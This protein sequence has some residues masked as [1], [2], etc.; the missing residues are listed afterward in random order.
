MFLCRFT[1]LKLLSEIDV[2]LPRISVS[3]RI[4]PGVL[5]LVRSSKLRPIKMYNRPSLA[6]YRGFTGVPPRWCHCESGTAEVTSLLGV[7]RSTYGVLSNYSYSANW[8]NAKAWAQLTHALKTE[9]TEIHFSTST[10]ACQ[11]SGGPQG[12]PHREKC[13][14]L[15]S[16]HPLP[17]S[18]GSLPPL[19]ASSGSPSQPANWFQFIGHIHDSQIP[20]FCFVWILLALQSVLG[21]RYSRPA[22]V[23]LQSHFPA[24]NLCRIS[25]QKWLHWHHGVSASSFQHT[26]HSLTSPCIKELEVF[27]VLACCWDRLKLHALALCCLNFVMSLQ[28]WCRNQTF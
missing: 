3:C 28:F 2:F 24:L 11:E 14:R 5:Q 7:A 27:C 12:S 6:G 10:T 20:L 15:W 17:N 8:I 26:T 13:F 21:E 18:H 1:V 23:H 25:M 4:I 22:C 9:N 19:L 16:I